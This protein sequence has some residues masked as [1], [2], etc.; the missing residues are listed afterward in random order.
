MSNALVVL[1]SG[2]EA[3]ILE[4]SSMADAPLTY[5]IP[6]QKA[7]DTERVRRA[8][9][10]GTSFIDHEI[11]GEN[12]TLFNR[13]GEDETFLSREQLIDSYC[14]NHFEKPIRGFDEDRKD[15]LTIQQM[16]EVSNKKLQDWR[17]ENTR[18][19]YDKPPHIDPK[20]LESYTPVE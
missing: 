15:G 4:W 9:W 6:V 17:K 5:G 7:P 14:R 12:Y 3:W 1:R 16:E 20:I 19:G 8:L 10:N 13:A 2:E 11:T 18:L